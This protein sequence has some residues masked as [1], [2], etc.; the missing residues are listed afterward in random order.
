LPSYN[1]GSIPNYPNYFLGKVPGSPCDTITGL[2]E[3]I[4]LELSVYPNPVIEELSL[5]YPTRSVAGE[6]QIFDSLGKLVQE[7][8]F[9]SYTSIKRFN[10]SKFNSGLYHCRIQW[11]D[12]VTISRK[13]L[14][15]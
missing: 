6:I 4:K 5:T 3:F 11:K 9:S 14:K 8:H 1:I 2:N 7:D 15:Q 10:L 13:F 12:G